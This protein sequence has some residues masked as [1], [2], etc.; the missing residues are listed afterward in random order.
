[1]LGPNLPFYWLLL[2]QYQSVTRISYQRR[3][4]TPPFSIYLSLHFTF[5]SSFLFLYLKVV[6]EVWKRTR[7]LECVSNRRPETFL[8]GIQSSVKIF[9]SSHAFYRV[10]IFF[11]TSTPKVNKK[12]CVPR[13]VFQ[14]LVEIPP[15]DY[16]LIRSKKYS[17]PPG[18]DFL[19][20]AR[21]LTQITTKY[22]TTQ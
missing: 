3:I 15:C 2:S 18:Q 16:L 12:T 17:P 20:P 6:E 13:P 4:T 21:I 7:V 14:C 5:L 19:H 1:M 22:N 8:Y 11:L 9:Q 10:R